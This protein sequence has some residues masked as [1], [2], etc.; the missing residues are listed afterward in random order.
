M[1]L[2]TSFV[3]YHGCGNDFILIDELRGKKIP[4]NKRGII[5]KILCKRR[6]GIGADDVL[7]LTPSQKADAMMRIFEPDG[8]EAEMS[9]NGVRCVAA[10]L[11]EKIHKSRILIDTKSGTRQAKKVGAHYRLNMGKLETTKS[12]IG[13]FLNVDA[14]EGEKFLNGKFPFHDMKAQIKLS[15]VKIGEPHVVVFVDDVGS[16]D[17]FYYGNAIAKN[18]DLFPYG[19]NV[20]LVQT[21]NNST[22]Q[23]RTYERGVWDETLA[24]GTGSVAAAAVSYI[25]G[26]VKNTTIK[27]LMKGGE[28]IVEITKESLFLSG[29]A[30]KVYDGFIKVEL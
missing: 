2:D 5:A 15:I 10:Y 20:N 13:K 30:T 3:K 7:Y 8:S 21:I 17:I 16:A 12:G 19:I 14:P 24:C 18:K 26:K 27:T 29:P 1:Q 28:Q 4:E 23:L 25:L 22:I 11:H 6:F 9:G